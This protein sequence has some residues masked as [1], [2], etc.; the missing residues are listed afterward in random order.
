LQVGKLYQATARLA[1]LLEERFGMAMPSI[2]SQ[3][4]GLRYLRALSLP[5]E[6]TWISNILSSKLGLSFDYSSKTKKFEKTRYPEIYL[7]ALLVV[8][9]KVSTAYSHDA[10]DLSATEADFHVIDFD[11]EHWVKSQLKVSNE[12]MTPTYIPD[13]FMSLTE[14]DVFH[15]TTQELDGY[16]AWYSKIWTENSTKSR[17]EGRAKVKP[18]ERKFKLVNRWRTSR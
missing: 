6:F 8:A 11:W 13:E 12:E 17:S 3:G 18:R 4:L 2:A 14:K 1:G 5:L 7:L 10:Q 9:A 16:M 15:M